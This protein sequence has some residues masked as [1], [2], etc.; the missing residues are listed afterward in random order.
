MDADD[1]QRT[2]LRAIRAAD[3]GLLLPPGDEAAGACASCR[4][5][6][7]EDEFGG[8]V[9]TREGPVV[10]CDRPECL[11]HVMRGLRD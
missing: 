10:F 2:I 8:F 7:T 9:K 5:R 4:R 3:L 11:E 6:I 1:R